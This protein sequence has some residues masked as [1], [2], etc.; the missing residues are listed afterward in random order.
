MD[1]QLALSS[2]AVERYTLGELT[3]SEKEAFE[4]HFFNC[5]ECSQ[6]LQE[7]EMFTANARA[8]FKE[9]P[10]TR[11]IVPVKR[12]WLEE[13]R[14]WLGWRTLIPAA[15]AVV[16]AFVLLRSPGT[17]DPLG[18]TK[19][20]VLAAD[21]RGD[22]SRPLKIAHSTVWLELQMDLVAGV[23]ANRWVSYHWEVDGPNGA[24][25]EQ[26]DRVS[27]PLKLKLAASKFEPGK[28]YKL[29]VQGASGT[30]PVQSDFV[31]EKQ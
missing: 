25:V 21:V 6:A 2:Q 7:Y 30:N 14:N 31:I 24:I 22:E 28:E 4:A 29:V 26:R 3:S 16:L 17:P 9:D 20:F 13:L 5:P 19:V 11:Q 12:H 15:A 1:H 18:E 10:L 23:N 27:G 8:V